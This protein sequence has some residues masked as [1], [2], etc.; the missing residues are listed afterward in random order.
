MR[1]GPFSLDV[2]NRRLLRDGREVTLAPKTFDLLVLLVNRAGDLVTKDEVLQALWPDAFVEEANLTQQVF[3]LRKALGQAGEEQTYI[4][5]VPRAGYRFVAPVAPIGPVTPPAAAPE[6]RTAAPMASPWRRI[7]MF[8]LA[9]A[10]IAAGAWWWF[11]PADPLA[12]RVATRLTATGDVGAAALS[13][14]GRVVAYVR[15]RDGQSAIWVQQR[16]TGQ[17]ARV[18]PESL[19]LIP[20]V[21][22]DPA[23]DRVY[24]V[25]GGA[26]PSWWSVPV[27]G[28]EPQ[29]VLTGFYAS[30]V[31]SPDGEQAAYLRADPDTGAHT[32]EIVTLASGDSMTLLR[33]ERPA[34]MVTTSS[35]AWSPDGRQIAVLVNESYGGQAATI[36]VADVASGDTET[37]AA[38]LP[39]NAGQLVWL[40]DDS[41]W[42]VA[43]RQLYV[44]ERKTGRL[45]PVTSD[46][47]VYSAMTVSRDGTVVARRLEETSEV[48]RL[49]EGASGEQATR[50]FSEQGY[51][52][53]ISWLPDG[54]LAYESWATGDAEI[55]VTPR[56]PERGPQ[57]LTMAPGYD[58]FPAADPSGASV[59]YVS[60]VAGGSTLWRAPLDGRPAERIGGDGAHYAPDVSPDG[61]SIVYHAGDA[62]LGWSLWR[63]DAS[64][65][66]T[67]LSDRPATFGVYSPD[68]RWVACN[69]LPDG[70]ALGWSMAILPAEGGAPAQVLRIPGSATRRLAW[71]R[72]GGSLYWTDTRQTLRQVDRATGQS[73]IVLSYPGEDILALA[74]SRWSG[75]L[76]FV[77][78]RTSADLVIWH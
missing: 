22:F 29:R 48:W 44:V 20:H 41:G 4:A 12:D 61:R 13:P 19:G 54:R 52:H 38:A 43:A 32:L 65:V 27:V 28:G 51:N 55:R 63:V 68:G 70:P 72:D 16:A 21:S 25:R 40:P 18:V 17:A 58:A 11:A 45:R 67:R 77:R 42:L 36:V 31:L 73:R 33:R 59:V 46:A 1:F 50:W 26:A 62:E 74:V 49:P 9:V 60:G 8:G 15:S 56:S 69:W 75:D 53:G 24:F 57:G 47:A 7:A 30:P 3:L 14:D 34:V 71:S 76:A 64:G 39:W 66:E 10:V 37:I 2:A 5:T 6:P 78:H 23:G 35:P